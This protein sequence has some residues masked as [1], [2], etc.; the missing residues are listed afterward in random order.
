[1]AHRLIGEILTEISQ[2]SVDVL[3]ESLEL[4]KEKS[5]KIGEILIERKAL[6]ESDLLKALGI[7][8]GLPFLD[9]LPAEDLNADFTILPNT[10][11]FIFLRN[12]R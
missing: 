6:A 12:T 8:F 7:Q 1:V 4:Q 11:P 3:S 9:E 2:L 10:S 5:G